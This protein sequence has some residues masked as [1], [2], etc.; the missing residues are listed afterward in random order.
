MGLLILLGFV[1]ALFVGLSILR[2]RLLPSPI[3]QM[4]LPPSGAQPWRRIRTDSLNDI[5]D[6][7]SAPGTPG[8]QNDWNNWPSNTSRAG[9]TPEIISLPQGA[10]ATM[11][12]DMGYNITNNNA[13]PFP[14]TGAFPVGTIPQ[15][16]PS[17]NTAVFPNTTAFS[18]P[19]NGNSPNNNNASPAT[20]GGVSPA[21]NAADPQSRPFQATANNNGVSPLSTVEQSPI[22]AGVLS[23]QATKTA[24][25]LHPVPGI[26]HADPITENIKPLARQISK[27]IRLQNIRNATPPPAA[28]NPV[29]Q[30][31]NTEPISEEM[32][33]LDDLFIRET[34]K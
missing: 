26:T 15:S 21:P 4:S 14:S 30:N 32:P 24:S 6:V 5:T 18:S 27:P 28:Q 8:V 2:K 22:T 33:S 17:P 13:F 12:S 3:P 11:A 7:Q 19:N 16:S 10:A 23:P 25:S 20:S 9:R 34:L 29:L 1:G 31:R